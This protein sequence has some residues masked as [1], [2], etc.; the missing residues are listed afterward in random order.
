MPLPATL[1]SW[2]LSEYFESSALEKVSVANCELV[3]GNLVTS[4]AT[5]NTQSLHSLQLK[6]LFPVHHTA[7]HT[8]V[9]HHSHSLRY[10]Y[11]LPFSSESEN[12]KFIDAVKQISNILTIDLDWK[13]E[14]SLLFI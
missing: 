10:L 5:T 14:R 2:I 1:L 12:E 8:L 11:L 3:D 13:T 7:F 6:L 4:L 9:L